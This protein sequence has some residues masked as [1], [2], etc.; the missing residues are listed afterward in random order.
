MKKR[1]FVSLIMAVLLSLPVFAD[2]RTIYLHTGGPLFWSK[3][4]PVL[5]IY[6]WTD[7]KQYTNVKLEHL[8]NY[9]YSAKLDK[10]Y[11]NLMFVKFDSNTTSFDLD[12]K[13]SQTKEFVLSDAND[14]FTV[15]CDLLA[16]G[17]D[18]FTDGYW[19][20]YDETMKD[21]I[22]YGT[23]GDNLTW[24]I[25]EQGVLDISGSGSMKD[26][27]FY[28]YTWS[29]WYGYYS[30]ITS[31]VLPQ[32]I[33]N[34]GSYAFSYSNIT[35]ITIPSTVT[36]IGTEALNCNSL[37]SITSNATVPPTITPEPIG[38][39][40]EHIGTNLDKSIPLYVPKGSVDTYKKADYWKDFT[41]IQ[42]TDGTEIPEETKYTITVKANNDAYGTVT[43]SGTYKEGTEVTLI[44]TPA[45]N[46]DFVK[47]NDGKT[48]NPRFVTVLSDSV[49]IAQFAPKGG[50]GGD[51][52]G[53][54]TAITVAEAIEAT[55]AL[56]DG[57]TSDKEV[58]IEGYVV[59]AEDFDW[60][61]KNQVFYLSDTK[62]NSGQQ[63]FYAYRCKA[64]ENGEAV[65][66]LDGD[67]V[68][69][70]GKLQKY[71]YGNKIIPEINNGTA[72]FVSKV[73]GD[74]SEHPV[75]QI[76]VSKALE[77]ASLLAKYETG[78]TIYTIIGYVTHIAENNFNNG[79]QN[80]TFWMADT[81]GTAA[82]NAEGAFYVYRA[83]PDVEL[84]VGD[85]V[86]VTT[87]LKNFN[88]VLE[89]ETGM[90]VKRLNQNPVVNTLLPE[91]ID[92]GLPSGIRWSGMNVGAKTETGYGN[93]YQ[94]GCTTPV[95]REG[96]DSYCHGTK[97]VLTKYCTDNTFGTVDNKTVLDNA[98]DAA[99]QTWGEGWRMPTKEEAE[100][101]WN[102]CTRTWHI[103]PDCEG[104][105][106]TGPNGNSIFL[107]SQG[108]YD[109]SG[110]A[111]SVD[112]DGFYWTSTLYDNN[113]NG[114]YALLTRQTTGEDGVLYGVENRHFARGI[115]GVLPKRSC[116]VT[117]SANV[118]ITE[119]ESFTYA[120][121]TVTPAAGQYTYSA[122]LAGA[123][124]CDSVLIWN[125]TVNKASVT[126]YTLSA[127]SNDAR[128]GFVSGGGTYKSGETIS[129]LAVP[130]AK[131]RFVKW[132]DGV[133]SNPRTVIMTKDYTFTAI[134]AA[135]AGSAE[136]KIGEQQEYDEKKDAVDPW[137]NTSKVIQ[138]G[139]IYILRN[140]KMYTVQG[141][142]VK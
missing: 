110:V 125:V 92:L 39:K 85:K 42:T 120:G 67:K 32:N 36:S 112:R 61:S 136:E 63:V 137:A 13:Q 44:A 4:N 68:R 12:K 14:M 102:N 8:Q 115:R 138:N 123:N 20:K 43:G 41:N 100:E 19:S 65:P 5:Y 103:T 132:N 48:D 25:N 78:A 126:M 11:T 71:I 95:T 54:N 56:A 84:V 139:H 72:T 122:I 118:T 141:Q 134:F 104:Y 80:M 22:A 99:A 127:K 15:T 69:L 27:S 111:H 29:P 121:K 58:T 50:G 33:P 87:K 45:T 60:A 108:W 73:D 79:Y 21:Y 83:K 128:L 23:C 57:A 96:W 77:L 117:N 16:D 98:D 74:R 64:I 38:K 88:G 26:Y 107:P 6:A 116:R 131:C 101:L 10:T 142:E 31:V 129:V 140:G 53:G 105:I 37:T 2:T 34:I 133:T 70:T 90:T 81:K 75:E 94:W 124:G 3:N 28:Y 86:S 49:F 35:T 113:N 89:S 109:E 30:H 91:A 59:D 7:G 1:Y 47:W 76:S 18:D 17:M 51:N 24:K 97:N 52:P 106:F 40:T 135:V 93:F 55:N 114:A 9:L 62:N 119:G 66:V 130:T 46:Y 82:S